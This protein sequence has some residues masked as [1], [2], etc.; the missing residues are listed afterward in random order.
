MQ[1]T[2]EEKNLEAMKIRRSQTL[3]SSLCCVIGTIIFDLFCVIVFTVDSEEKGTGLVFVW[4]FTVG[5]IVVQVLSGLV[6][7][8]ELKNKQFLK[9]FE[10]VTKLCILLTVGAFCQ[11]IVTIMVS[12]L[13]GS[14]DIALS[15][16]LLLVNTFMY[17]GSSFMILGFV[18]RMMRNDAKKDDL[19]VDSEDK[20]DDGVE[21]TVDDLPEDSAR[22]V[23][24]DEDGNPI[25][26]E[27]ADKE[28]EGMNLDEPEGLH[29]ES[30]VELNPPTEAT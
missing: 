14:N 27:A 20:K 6:F 8:T 24:L 2:V 26:V 5:K 18:L 3:R 10:H 23:K 15:Y 1:S 25:D 7:A 22:S 12:A 9:H 19:K 17:L 4:I 11:L 16:I 30:N 29:E 13:F 21:A 28:G